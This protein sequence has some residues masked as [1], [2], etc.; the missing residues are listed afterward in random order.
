MKH[1]LLFPCGR[2]FAAVLTVAVVQSAR[3]FPDPGFGEG[4]FV[5]GDVYTSAQY[6]SIAMQADGRIVVAGAGSRGV[7]G[8]LILARYHADGR[9]DESF[10][11]EGRLDA[12]APDS[13]GFYGRSVA[14]QAD[15]KIVVAGT[16]AVESGSAFAVARYHS[17]GSVD[18]SFGTDGKTITPFVEGELVSAECRA[19]ALQANGKIVLA[20]H[21][22]GGSAVHFALARYLGDG[23]PD[24]GFGGDGKVTT[25]FAGYYYDIDGYFHAR[26]E[27]VAIQ[28]DGK[29]VMAGEAEYYDEIADVGGSPFALARYH[30]D[31]SLDEDFMDESEIS[32]TT[33]RTGKVLTHF[34][35]Y[36]SAKGRSVAVQADGRIVVSGMVIGNYYE[37]AK[38]ALARY[39]T[40]GNLDEHFG[41]GGQVVTGFGGDSMGGDTSVDCTGMALQADGKIVVAGRGGGDGHGGGFHGI[42]LAR[43]GSDGGLD[44]GFGRGGKMLGA[45]GYG[46]GVAVQE[47]GGILVSGYRMIT[48][49]P[50]QSTPFLARFL[51][52][53]LAPVPSPPHR[54][55]PAEGGE[56]DFQ[57][58]SSGYLWSWSVSEGGDWVG[59]VHPADSSGNGTLY[60]QVAPNPGPEPRSATVTLTSGSFTA[61]HTIHQVGAI[62]RDTTPPELEILS[63][64]EGAVLGPVQP[65]LIEAELGDDLGLMDFV[66][67]SLNGS[68]PF[69]VEL[70]SP[71]LTEKRLEWGYQLPPGEHTFVITAYDR[72]GNSTSVTRS[73]TFSFAGPHQPA[74]RPALARVSKPKRFPVTRVGK[75]SRPQTLRIFNAGGSPLTGLHVVASGRARRDFLLVRPARKTLAP[76]TSTVFKATFRPRSAGIRRAVVGVRS[77]ASLVKVPLFGR[78]RARR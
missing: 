8:G 9:P 74:P 69:L 34:T 56:R 55:V 25:S 4:G 48:I 50:A 36:G 7:H 53:D 43:Y 63:P 24:T 31:G 61:T 11:V 47:D 37:P 76:S 10:S 15:G 3:A 27:S 14:I 68:E 66:E 51:E 57:V 32:P 49:V 54:V 18:T 45:P 39:S 22:S 16:V 60:Y 21:A 40:A 41:E 52:Y 71:G 38:F 75:R 17:D 28:A 26:G 78:G 62:P 2:I 5:P 58:T 13:Y 44:P 35:G 77:N 46:Q 12:L 30:S 23:S 67:I 6:S 42:V 33:H 19:M 72:A 1:F 64:V 73:F 59:S 20:G 29:I 70:D 65:I